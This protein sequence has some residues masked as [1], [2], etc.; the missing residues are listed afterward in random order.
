M[1]AF[2]G[3]GAAGPNWARPGFE[4][5]PATPNSLGP[6]SVVCMALTQA[7]LPFK[8]AQVP[9]AFAVLVEVAIALSASSLL[10]FVLSIP[11]VFASLFLLFL[12]VVR[13]ADEPALPLSSVLVRPHWFADLANLQTE[14]SFSPDFGSV[15]QPLRTAFT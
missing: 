10:P 5:P 3:S 7:S 9:F 1:S 4:R 15:L 2:H 8:V 14:L 13:P 11:F 12:S 6:F